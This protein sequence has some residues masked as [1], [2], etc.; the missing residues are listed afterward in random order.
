MSNLAMMMG[1]GSGAGGPVWNALD[2]SSA[3]YDS[4]SFSVNSQDTAPQGIKFNSDGT[5]MY[6]VGS[7]N[8]NVYQYSLSTAWDLST[9]SYDSINFYV[10][11]QENVPKS[12]T[13]N[14]DGTS[15]YVNGDSSDD[16]FQYTLSTAWDLSTASYASK[17][18]NFSTVDGAFYGF[19]FNNDGTK[20]YL[21]GSNSDTVYQY[22]MSTAYDVS[23]LSSDSV[24]LNVTNEAALPYDITFSSTGEKL[25]VIGFGSIGNSVVFQYSLSTA[26]D[27][28]TASY[29]NDYLDPDPIVSDNSV[30]DAAFKP[31]GS[32]M[33]L[34]GDQQNTVYQFTTA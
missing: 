10:G 16:I 2:I 7:A 11:S 26:W 21:V 17:S 14:A 24:T 9:A 3:S 20:G 12:L 15:M 31:D 25:Y 28:S 1:L 27:L 29:D 8:D 18:F 33:Y 34:L 4:V 30:K 5:K 6:I 23:T 13:F 32:K 22:S 19:S